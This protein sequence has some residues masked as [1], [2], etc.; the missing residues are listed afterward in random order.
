MTARDGQV[1]HGVQPPPADPP[2]PIGDRVRRREDDRDYNLIGAGAVFALLIGL[3]PKYNAG[4][5]GALLGVAVV[6]DAKGNT[7]NQIDVSLSF[8][9]SPYRL[10]VERVDPAEADA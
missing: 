6:V 9:D 7:T 1:W 5:S 10:T 8:I 3:L 2:P 4:R